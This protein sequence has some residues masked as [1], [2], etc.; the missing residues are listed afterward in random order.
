METVFDVIQSLQ[1]NFSQV[2]VAGVLIFIFGYVIGSL[3]I[4]RMAREKHDLEK[5][6]MA[7]NEELL[8]GLPSAFQEKE[9]E[10]TTPVIGLKTKNYKNPQIAK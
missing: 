6:V 3:R 4:K 10:S 9:A 2:V 8:Y 7:L 5:T 1:L